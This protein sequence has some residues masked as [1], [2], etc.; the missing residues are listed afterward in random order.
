[1]SLPYTSGDFTKPRAGTES[2]VEYPFIE[3]GDNAT[4]VYHLVCVVNEANYTPIALDTTMASATN[5]DVIDLP[6]AADATAYFVGDYNKTK[7]EGGLVRFDRQFADI[8]ASRSSILT[9]TS[10]YTFPG[11]EADKDDTIE[12]TAS[13][14]SATSTTTTLTCTNTVTVGDTVLC[15]LSTTD[16][17][18]TV[19]VNRASRTA[20]AGTTTSQVVV[21]RLGA[22]TTFVSGSVEEF[23]VQPRG[24]TTLATGTFTDFTYYLPGVTSGITVPTDVALSETFRI[25]A[26]L[27]N[28]GTVPSATEYDAK[29][30]NGDLLLIESSITRYAGNIIQRADVKVKAQ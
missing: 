15:S 26:P 20:L 13:G 1:M 7:I 30:T 28:P 18:I 9:G 3:E 19:T 21:S 6:F 5:A 8:P 29:V 25:Q 17:S 14:F 12:R 16:G 23:N 4:K 27:L 2:W 10:A 22:S 11:V 24:S